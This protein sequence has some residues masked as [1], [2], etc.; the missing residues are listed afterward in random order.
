MK[1]API[2]AAALLAAGADAVRFVS[3]TLGQLAFYH[4]S[5]H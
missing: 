5:A 3:E 4:G 1:T 2:V